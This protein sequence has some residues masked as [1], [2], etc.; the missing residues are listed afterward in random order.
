MAF[1]TP[2]SPLFFKNYPQ[3]LWISLLTDAEKIGENI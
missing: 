2:V 3:N 1:R